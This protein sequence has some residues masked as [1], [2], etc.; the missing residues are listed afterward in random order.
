MINS[1]T[2]TVLRNNGQKIPSIGLGVF[3]IPNGDTA[4]IVE[5]AIVSGYRSIDIAAIY[6]NEAGT[7][8]GPDPD[9]FDFK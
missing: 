7:S 5:K 2:D 6:G 8:I 1:L 3:Q 9:I 4:K